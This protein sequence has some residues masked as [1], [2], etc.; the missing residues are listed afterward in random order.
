[1][2]EQ[3]Q[4][5][6]A[7]EDGSLRAYSRCGSPEPGPDVLDGLIGLQPPL[8]RCGRA[9]VIDAVAVLAVVRL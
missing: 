8:R 1:M 7:Y 9:A 2:S 6:I 4:L 5:T 3:L